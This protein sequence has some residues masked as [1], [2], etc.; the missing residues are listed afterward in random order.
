MQENQTWTVKKRFY[1]S[2]NEKKEK[3]WHKS[4][5]DKTDV[6]KNKQHIKRYKGKKGYKFKLWTVM[7]IRFKIDKEMN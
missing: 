7:D 3:L 5:I 4:T 6:C 1:D 2:S